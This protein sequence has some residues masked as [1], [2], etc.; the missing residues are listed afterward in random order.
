MQYRYAKK[1]HNGD[2]VIRKE[3]KAV[4]IVNSVEVYP[5]HKWVR[6]NCI[7]NDSKYISLIHTE[8]E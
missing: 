3:D 5:Q 2:E 6:I 8:I 4:F 1:L 7:G